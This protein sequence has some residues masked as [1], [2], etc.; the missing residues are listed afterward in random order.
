[1]RKRRANDDVG[2]RTGK[3]AYLI[4]IKAQK[5]YTLT[6]QDRLQLATLL[7]KAGY[8]VHIGREQVPESKTKKYDY[9]VTAEEETR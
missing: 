7:I 3:E 9:Y 1:L 4:K 6:E 8:I 2:V 5:N